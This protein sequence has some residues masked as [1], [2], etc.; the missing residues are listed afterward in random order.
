MKI[1]ELKAENFKRISALT[2]KPDGSAVVIGGAN[3][4]GKS[5]TLDAIE[6]A[7]GGGRH[8]PAE[9]IKRGEK[10][11]RVVIETEDLTV[12]RKW[13]AKGTTLEVKA[14]DGRKYP[15]PQKMLDELIGGLSFDPLAFASMDPKKQADTLRALVG[16]DLSALD[17]ER[18]AAYDK[19]TGANRD[20]KRIEGALA[21]VPAIAAKLP[22]EPVS[23]VDLTR[24]L[25]AGRQ[26]NAVN[27]KHR[28]ELAVTRQQAT[29]TMT[30][31]EQLEGDLAEAKE[32]L[33]RKKTYGAKLRANVDLLV[34]V[35]VEAIAAQIE[36]ASTTN[37]AIR[38]RDTRD[39][40]G[41]D[42]SAAYGAADQYTEQIDD[43]DQR[44]ADA[45]A[46]VE[47]PV[48]GLAAT[49]DGVTLDGVPFDQGS[50]A[51][52][53]RASVAIGLALNKGLRVMLIRQG[54]LLDDDGLGLV[55][56]MAD[57]AGVQP[58]IERV[59]KGDEV[60]VVIED[61][62]I[63]LTACRSSE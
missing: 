2:I 28:S 7:L 27:D 50:S 10:K 30:R 55:L 38:D 37:A 59:G 23:V 42:M 36:S 44:K 4:A 32:K 41:A 61:G 29:A 22:G 51:Q 18:A 49:D 9:P 17:E 40:L 34:D 47:Y 45:I 16:L 1:I 58:F 63:A 53:L 19:R 39:K 48:D 15:S 21:E 6:A 62:A 60:T 20:A 8:A 54:S 12:E 25:E 46:A 43:I 5:S 56:G 57:A 24:E 31:I 13:S 35:D 11:A 52:K 3:G 26:T 33:D 14:K